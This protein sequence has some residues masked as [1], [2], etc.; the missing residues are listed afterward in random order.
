MTLKRYIEQLMEDLEEAKNQA[1]VENPELELLEDE[2]S[3]FQLL[4]LGE[5]IHDPILHDDRCRRL[6]IDSR[7]RAPRTASPELAVVGANKTSEG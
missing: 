4:E 6:V 7:W 3:L 1:P 2:N 5:E